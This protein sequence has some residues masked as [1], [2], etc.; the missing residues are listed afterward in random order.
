[1]FLNKDYREMLTALNDA[2]AEYLIVGAY[3]LALFGN[4]RATGDIDIWVRPTL[5]NASKVWQ[6][7]EV[8]KAPKSNLRPE[9]FCDPDVV[10]QI[11]VAPFR[12][13]FLT[14]ID[15][16]TFDQAWKHRTETVVDQVKIAV[17]G[18]QELLANKLASGR[19]KDLVDATWLQENGPPPGRPTESS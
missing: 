19:P 14:A 16:V 9:D 10:Y 17:I 11:G 13:D 5:E 2:E 6:A 12:I 7:L 15:G 8:F 4:I 18:H 3:A 1:M